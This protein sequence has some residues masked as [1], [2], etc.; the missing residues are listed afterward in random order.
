[1]KSELDQRMAWYLRMKQS[2][3]YLGI[4]QMQAGMAYA[5]WARNAYVG[6]WLPE[7]RGFL[8]SRYKM[9]PTPYLFVEYHWETGEPFGTVKPLRPLEICP[10]PLVP[11]SAYHEERDNAQLCGWLDAL[12]E[13]HPPLSGWDSISERRQSI[14]RRA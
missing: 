9:Y 11:T 4:D 13:R 8:I 6:L 7:E 14:A 10:I 12:E 1:M 2:T 5:I 3:N